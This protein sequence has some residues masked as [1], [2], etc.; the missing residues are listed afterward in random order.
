MIQTQNWIAN[1]E[2][3]LERCNKL[4]L[5][6]SNE[7][8]YGTDRSHSSI[9]LLQ[10]LFKNFNKSAKIAGTSLCN[11]IISD[12]ECRERLDMFEF[13]V[14]MILTGA[15]KNIPVN[16]RDYLSIQPADKFNVKETNSYLTHIFETGER[17]IEFLVLNDIAYF[18]EHNLKSNGQ[19]GKAARCSFNDLSGA[20]HLSKTFDDVY[21]KH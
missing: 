7:E 9:L 14:S 17:E 16:L 2:Y 6:G 21:N 18:F 3:W 13:P 12:E 1:K 8:V 4:I 15:K 20:L 5:G 11:K 19:G 10:T